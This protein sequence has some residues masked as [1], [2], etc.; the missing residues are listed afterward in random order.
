MSTSDLKFSITDKTVVYVCLA[1]LNKIS[2]LEIEVK[3]IS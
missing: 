3:L 2:K 1:Q